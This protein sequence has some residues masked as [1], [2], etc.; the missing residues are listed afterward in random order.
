MTGPLLSVANLS[1]GFTMY[2]RGL[3]RRTSQVI[4]DLSVTVGEGEL[5]A[6]VGA[7][8]SGKSLL[9]NAIV[10]ILPANARVGGHVSYRGA[11]LTPDRVAALRGREIC[12]IPQSL[13]SF[14]PLMS[15]RR[16]VC[17]DPSRRERYQAIVA[18]SGLDPVQVNSLFPHELSGGMARRLLVATA[19]IETPRL[20]IADEPTPGMTNA[21]AE[22]TMVQFRERTDAGAGAMVITH[23]LE[24]ALA[25]AD[26]LVLFHDGRSVEKVACRD[27]GRQQDTPSA[28]YSQALWRAMPRNAF[29]PTAQRELSRALSGQ[30]VTAASPEKPWSP[31]P[32]PLRPL[33]RRETL[34]AR[35]I[36]F[37]YSRKSRMLFSGFSLRV[38]SGERVGLFGPSGYGKSTVGKLL[39]N[40]MP[41]TEGQIL[42]NGQRMPQS[43]YM[44]SQLIFQHPDQAVDPN[45]KILSA[46]E[47]GG[48][49]EQECLD[50]LEIEPD[51]LTRWPNELS[52]GQLQRVSVARALGPGTR[53]LVADEI[54]TMLDTISQA[55]I[56]RFLMHE[57]VRRQ[58]GLLVISHN[59]PLMERLCDRIVRMDQDTLSEVC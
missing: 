21:Q 57:V 41:P 24:L 6:V 35:S 16:Q 42:L 48:V 3:R 31:A 19:L 13:K 26:R 43:G 27:F 49:P 38:Q 55:H 37:R 52:G 15:L 29:E 17:R 11:P 8:G 53:F 59:M 54:S 33:G 44:P 25:H 51:W 47:E 23:D 9:A 14:D 34:E 1:I 32:R 50:A 36:G 18:R 2:E 46:L 45:R 30:E 28:F 10:S 39:C 4:T 22:E 56:W 12:L 40:Y 5:V 7:S 58:L 20:I